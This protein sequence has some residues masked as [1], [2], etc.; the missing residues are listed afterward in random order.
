[1]VETKFFGADLSEANFTN[2]NLQRAN[3]TDAKISRAIFTLTK[4]QGTIGTNGQPWGFTVRS[5]VAKKPWWK[6]WHTDQTV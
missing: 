5:R 2:A 3:M 6:V 4:M 1:M